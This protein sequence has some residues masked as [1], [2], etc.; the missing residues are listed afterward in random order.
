MSKLK[1]F[2]EG[3][4]IAEDSQESSQNDDFEILKESPMMGDGRFKL[5]IGTAYMP[6]LPMSWP[7]NLYSVL[8]RTPDSENTASTA[9]PSSPQTLSLYITLM[10]DFPDADIDTSAS[11]MTAIKC[12]DD[13]IGE[14]GARADFVWELWQ[15]K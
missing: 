9:T 3:P 1:D 5:E 10:L 13:R 12:Q 6:L 7:L 4:E 11:I 14:R 2:V 8:A 15:D